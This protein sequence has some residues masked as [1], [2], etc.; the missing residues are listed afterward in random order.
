MCQERKAEDDGILLWCSLQRRRTR[1]IPLQNLFNQLEETER[2]R[3]K[4]VTFILYDQS[5]SFPETRPY[6]TNCKV[7]K[8]NKRNSYIMHSGYL[9]QI[10]ICR[11]AT[12]MRRLI[13]AACCTHFSSVMPANILI[14]QTCLLIILC[15][16]RRK[17]NWDAFKQATQEAYSGTIL[18]TVK[19]IFSSYLRQKY[20]H[21][22]HKS[23]HS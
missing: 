1:K 17:L 13:L 10:C 4:K 8:L 23:S 15:K 19:E 21:T 6:C 9:K 11:T 5:Y 16:H 18:L 12:E 20:S 2:G 22:T 3:R 7:M 14:P